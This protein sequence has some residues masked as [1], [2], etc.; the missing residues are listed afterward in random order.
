MLPTLA[1]SLPGSVVTRWLGIQ[2][3]G[4]ALSA[5]AEDLGT[6]QWWDPPPPHVPADQVVSRFQDVAHTPRYLCRGDSLQ[7]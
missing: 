5:G 4:D 3:P 1:C 7:V 6:G 2:P